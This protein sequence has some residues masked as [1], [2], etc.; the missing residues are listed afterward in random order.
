MRDLFD[1]DPAFALERFQD[2]IGERN[3]FLDMRGGERPR[4]EHLDHLIHRVLGLRLDGQLARGI[5]ARI[6]QRIDFAGADIRSE[7]QHRA[8]HLSQ[9]RAVIAGNP[10][11][12]RDQFVVENRLRV[13]QAQGVFE[14][15]IRRVVVHPQYDAGQ[16]PRAERNQHTRARLY[17]M[18][19]GQGKRIGESLIQ[20]HRQA[21]VAKTGQSSV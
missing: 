18:L 16:L 11:A 14:R 21:D 20:R 10:F 19:Q 8:Q 13:D 12:Q 7:R 6:G 15:D 9:R 1:G 2:A 17:A 3:L 5:A 4:G